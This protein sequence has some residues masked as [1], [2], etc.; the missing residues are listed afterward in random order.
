MLANEHVSFRED[1]RDQVLPGITVVYKNWETVAI[2]ARK[3]VSNFWVGN[4]ARCPIILFFAMSGWLLF[5]QVSS[6]EQLGV[7]SFARDIA[8]FENC[9]VSLTSRS[10]IT[11]EAFCR[12]NGNVLLPLFVLAR[13]GPRKTR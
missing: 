5:N 6:K 8:P 11:S 1:K 13:L 10:E 12:G 7:L 9:D 4:F 2:S 3:Q